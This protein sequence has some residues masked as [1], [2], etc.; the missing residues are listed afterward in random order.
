M[1]RVAVLPV[2]VL[3]PSMAHAAVGPTAVWRHSEI[4]TGLGSTADVDTP[5]GLQKWMRERRRFVTWEREGRESSLGVF[6]RTDTAFIVNGRT[7][8]SA[9]GDAG[10]QVMAGLIGALRH[11]N[12]RRVLVIGLGSGATAGWLAAVPSV[13][14]VDVIELEPAMLE[15][16]RRFTPVNLGALDNPKVKVQIGDAREQLLTSSEHYDLIFSE[17]SNPFRSGIASLF[18]QELYLAARDRLAPGGV[19]VQWLQAYSID[20]VAARTAYATLVSVFPSVESWQSQRRDLTLVCRDRDSPIDVSELRRVLATPPFRRAMQVAWRTDVV[21]GLLARH[22]ASPALAREVAAAGAINTDDKNLLEFGFARTIG[23]VDGLRIPEMRA[24]AAARGASRPE[25]AG[26]DANVDWARVVREI[27]LIDAFRETG[28]LERLQREIAA[29]PRS[30]HG[31]AETSILADYHAARGDAAAEP[32]I[33]RL[34]AVQPV[35]AS[36]LLARLRFAQ[37]R[38]AE[39]AAAVA[40]T[41]AGYRE[42]AWPLNGLIQNTLALTVSLA[43]ADRAFAMRMFD[44][45]AQPFALDQMR[46]S[47]LIAR[48]DLAEA[49]A[50]N[51]RCVTALLAF[52]PHFPWT[53][54]MLE[55]RL[56]CYRTA[57]H[58][59]T[60][61]AQAELARFVDQEGAHF[62]AGLPTSPAQ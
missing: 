8:G 17:P 4:A 42:D 26:A 13:E 1:A 40:Q 11:G 9:I 18:T 62:D 2:V 23:R 16:A 5:N 54:A 35:E 31:F 21:E 3:A 39:A 46:E 34:R 33:E 44:E 15:V 28:V 37:K 36:A 47:R 58:R 25:L 38:H 6:R 41:L 32:L 22:V 30:P 43:V 48:L 57:G 29:D 45:L 53:K 49:L 55:R 27:A 12:V 52:E 19:F 20:A 14:R 59:L 50:D 60:A 24:L 7:D 56:R 10:T 51:A 61:R